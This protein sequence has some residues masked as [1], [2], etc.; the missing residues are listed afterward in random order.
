MRVLFIGLIAI[1][2][3]CSKTPD[4]EKA[5]IPTTGVKFTFDGAMSRDEASPTHKTRTTSYV[6]RDGKITA[7]SMFDDSLD[8][9]VQEF[10]PKDPVFQYVHSETR[11]DGKVDDGSKKGIFEVVPD[12]DGAFPMYANSAFKIKVKTT[13]SLTNSNSVSEDLETVCTVGGKQ[14]LHVPAGTYD[15]F[16]VKCST[17][18][19]KNTAITAEYNYAPEIGI[20]ILTEFHTLPTN[21]D[22][23]HFKD[24]KAIWTLK[25]MT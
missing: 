3:G 2:A 22:I 8:V 7:T 12:T 6:N 25:S 18:G 21:P 23:A 11:T 5:T 15:V 20:S 1:L 19:H 14:K 17:T 10:D 24:Q 16:P 13:F 4:V 9:A